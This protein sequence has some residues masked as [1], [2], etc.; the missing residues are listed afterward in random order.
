[1]LFGV[2]DISKPKSPKELLADEF[3]D[4]KMGGDWI[5]G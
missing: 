2:I 3:I 4:E 5:S 1:M